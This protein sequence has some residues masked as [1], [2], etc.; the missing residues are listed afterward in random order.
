M[1][2]KK[3]ER[4]FI[5]SHLPIIN[6]REDRVI[7][8]G[9]KCS[10]FPSIKC[11]TLDMILTAKCSPRHVKLFKRWFLVVAAAHKPRKNLTTQ[12]TYVLNA[13]R[14]CTN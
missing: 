12:R 5:I 14:Q 1:G 3:K 8:T 10:K 6:Q 2:E 9:E 4:M 11:N 13:R 7:T